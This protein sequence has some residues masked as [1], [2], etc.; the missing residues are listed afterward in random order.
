MMYDVLNKSR[1]ARLA[2]FVHLSM[3]SWQSGVI[4][5]AQSC[6]LVR[7]ALATANNLLSDEFI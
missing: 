3:H 7:Q 2:N 4:Y 5:Y 1:T 6:V